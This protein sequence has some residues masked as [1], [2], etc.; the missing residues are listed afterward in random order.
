MTGF[1]APRIAEF[2]IV[3]V[4]QG[5]NAQSLKDAPL[6]VVCDHVVQVYGEPERVQLTGLP[7]SV[8]ASLYPEVMA[9][10][11]A[12]FSLIRET[13][14]MAQVQE[15]LDR[16][17]D[18]MSV[19]SDA[20]RGEPEFHEALGA[21]R[22]WTSYN[23]DFTRQQE[24]ALVDWAWKEHTAGALKE[25][26]SWAAH[27]TLRRSDPTAADSW[28]TTYWWHEVYD[29]CMFVCVYHVGPPDLREL[30]TKFAPEFIEV[31][32]NLGMPAMIELVDGGRR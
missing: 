25:N 6:H 13:P 4:T 31:F 28:E 5:F 9:E 22:I 8:V 10:K 24:R 21:M 11:V 29:L 14:A 30:Y 26:L 23:S 20:G 2:P 27:E 18:F 1:T 19:V 15:L 7:V 17:A 3:D 12:A 32:S 16:V